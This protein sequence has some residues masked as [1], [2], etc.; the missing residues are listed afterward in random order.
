MRNLTTAALLLILPSTLWA[1]P[2]E[3][4]VAAAIDGYHAA[5]TRGDEKAALALLADDV[6][7]LE[8]GEVE[9]RAE[10]QSHHLAA[11]IRFSQAVPSTRTPLRV[12]VHGDTAWASARSET[13]GHFE[14]RAVDSAGAELMV[15]TRTAAGWRIRAI[16]WSAHTLKTPPKS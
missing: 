7:V 2:D 5:L 16:H 3:L 11:D 15:L 14:G 1:G 13:H 4:A 6:Q 9:S 12:T 8:S 10:Y